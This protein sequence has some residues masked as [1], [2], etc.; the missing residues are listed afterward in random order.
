VVAVHDAFER[1]GL[2]VGA[3]VVHDAPP[4]PRV[5]S[6]PIEGS[7]YTCRGTREPVTTARLLTL[8]TLNP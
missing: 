6:S 7:Q 1:P 4:D 3:D 2:Q 5:P 8:V